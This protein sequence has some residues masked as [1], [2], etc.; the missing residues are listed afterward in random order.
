MEM[1]Y[2]RKSGR[3]VGD[4]GGSG[5]TRQSLRKELAATY[6]EMGLS[7]KEA[8]LKVNKVHAKILAEINRSGNKKR[9]KRKKKK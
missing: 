8:W 9:Q 6:M 3:L 2:S 5:D 7:K 1:R 4:D